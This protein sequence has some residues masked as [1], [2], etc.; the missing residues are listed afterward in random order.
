MTNLVI[1]CSPNFL[2]QSETLSTLRFGQRA[3]LIKNKVV[4]K[5]YILFYARGP[6]TWSYNESAGIFYHHPNAYDD[7]SFAFITADLGAGKRV[8]SAPQPTGTPA[9]SV[10][11]FL[12]YLILF[13]YF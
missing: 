2:N 4:A 5:D 7:Y 8:S 11:E 10:S 1:T 13:Y 6:V 12:D 3:K 9:T